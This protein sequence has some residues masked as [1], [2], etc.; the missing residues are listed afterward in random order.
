MARRET[1]QNIS[2]MAKCGVCNKDIFIPVVKMWTYKRYDE[3]T[4][5]RLKYFC[6]W[7]CLRK[8]E[9]EYE[10]ETDRRKLLDYR[11]R[12]GWIKDGG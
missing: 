6:S 12:N 5:G 9:K 7:G 11:K 10:K 1:E 2:I 8:F 3:H 4:D